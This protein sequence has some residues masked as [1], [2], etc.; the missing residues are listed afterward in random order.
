M[1]FLWLQS[2]RWLGFPG[3]TDNYNFDVR[4]GSGGRLKMFASGRFRR[5]YATASPR[6][7]VHH[8]YIRESRA[9][10]VCVAV[11]G[12]ADP[13]TAGDGRTWKSRVRDTLTIGCAGSDVAWKLTCVDNEWI[14]TYSNCTTRT[15]TFILLHATIDLI[16]NSNH[17]CKNVFYF[18]YFWH[19]L[20][21]FDVFLPTFF[22]LFL[23]FV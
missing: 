18:F 19:I 10:D 13:P 12:C 16:A 22:I 20:N 2:A 7:S 3:G 4:C 17:T 5:S 14:G 15:S 11:I 8:E 6:C 9:V 21:V 1:R 23:F